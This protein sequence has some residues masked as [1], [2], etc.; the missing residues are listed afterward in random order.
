MKFI[1]RFGSGI[2]IA[3]ALL[4]TSCNLES[5]V[6]QTPIIPQSP[7]L[8][9]PEGEPIPVPDGISSVDFVKQMTIGWNLGNAFDASSCDAWA[10]SEGLKMEYKWL[11]HK[12]P[13]SQQLIK[14]VKDCGYNTI[15]IPVSWH[16]HMSK[17]TSDFKIDAAWM[18]RVKEVVDWAL[19]ENMYVII[20]LHHDNLT[21]EQIKSNPG[22]ALSTDSTVQEKS[23]TY[24]KRV[25]EQ[26]SETFK[27]YDEKLIFELLNEPRCVETGWEW[28]FWENNASKASTYCNII[29]NYEQVALNAIRA[30]GGKNAFRFVMAPGY[31]ASPDFLSSYKMP[32]DK[33]A[34][35]LILAAHAYTPTDFCLSG[36]KTDYDTNKSYIENSVNRVFQNLSNNYIKKGIGV[37]MGEAGISDKKNLSSREKWVEY[38]FTKAKQSGIPVILWDNEAIAPA[39]DLPKENGEYHG[40]FNRETCSLYYPTLIKKMVEIAGSNYVPPSIKPDSESGD[41]GTV[42]FSGVLDLTS[43]SVNKVIAATAFSNATNSSKLV[44]ETESCSEPAEYVNVK[45]QNEWGDSAVICYNGNLSGGTVG[46]GVLEPSSVTAGFTYTP[47]AVEWTAIKSKGLIVYGF[48]I[49]IT[50]I[51]LL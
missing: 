39:G 26:I 37:V 8:E 28:G 46:N 19:A 41:E 20:N 14:T 7:D 33:V 9:I 11:P 2:C 40:Y 44:F 25:W 45:M 50:K 36:T 4:F 27:N 23:R 1:L 42:I 18:N 47:T 5:G 32:K 49:K 43:W 51:T 34:D 3:L 16:N 13:T 17:N 38:Y 21:E 29:T 15:R 6:S 31:C 24:I 30:S 22:F 35:R 48:G 10:Y 12:Q